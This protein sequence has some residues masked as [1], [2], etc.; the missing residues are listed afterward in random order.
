MEDF[1]QITVG[2]INSA[3]MIVVVRWN[4]RLRRNLSI[5]W[6]CPPRAAATPRIPDA[7]LGWIAEGRK[8]AETARMP[9]PGTV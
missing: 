9:P 3:Q 8:R 5:G 4:F 7:R 6:P 1:H 2:M